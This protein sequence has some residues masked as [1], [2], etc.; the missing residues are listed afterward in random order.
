MLYMQSRQS[1]HIQE[2]SATKAGISVRSGYRIKT[3]ETKIK[4]QQHWLTRTDP[5]ASVWEAELVPLL[6][7]E[8]KLTGLTLWEYLDYKYPGDYPYKLL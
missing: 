3:G 7:K 4:A 2:T 8:P 1:G 6:A 5:F